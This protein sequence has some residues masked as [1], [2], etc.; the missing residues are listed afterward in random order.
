MQ[1]PAGH[2]T[3]Y[4]NNEAD[5]DSTNIYGNVYGG[6]H[7]PGRA[8][9]A[10]RS[11]AHQCLRDLR[12]THP[13]EDRA[14]IEDEKDTLLKDCYAWIL[15]DSGFRRWR[16]QADSQLLWIKGDPG[17]GKTMMIMGIIDELSQKDRARPSLRKIGSKH[18]LVAYF[19]CQRTRPELNNSVSVLRGLILLLV[20]KR[21]Q[22]I[23]HVQKRYETTGSKLFEGSN[24]IYALKE[25]LLDILND[26]SLPMTYLLVDALDECT[27]GLSAL[28]RI[29]ANDS[30]A[31]RSRVKWLVTSRNIPAIERYLQP[32]LAGIK[33][34]LELSA[35]HVSKAVAAYIDFKVRRLA[36]IRKY[37]HKTRAE[38]QQQLW[39]KAE[40][41]FLWV[42]LV[43]KELESMPLYSTRAVLHAIP[44]GLDPLYKRMME[45]ILA[46]KDVKTV[47]YCK[48]VLRSLTIAFRPLR[49]EELV[50]VA[51]LPGDQFNDVQGVADLVSYC[52]SFL[53]IRQDMVSFIHLS[54]K[55]FF[56]AGNSQQV[57]NGVVAEEQGRM[58]YRLLNVM[59]STLQRD[60]CGL[61]KLG[62]RTQEVAEQIK[63]SILPRIAYACEYWVDHLYDSNLISL[64]SYS[65]VLHNGSIVDVFLREKFLYWLEALSLCKNMS[66]GVVSIA[67]LKALTQGRLDASALNELV[68]DAHRFIMTHKSAIE[69][70]PLQAY[71]SALLF[72]PTRS[73]I[74]GLF[75]IEEPDWITIK[76][77][78]QEKWSPCLQTLEGHS[79]EV[80]S[81]RLASGS[82]S[83]LPWDDNTVK[84]WDVSSGERLHTL[85]GHSGGVNSIAFSHDSTRL[86]S[87]SGLGLPWDD[88]NTVKIWDVSSGECLHTLKGYSSAANSVAFSHDSTRLASGSSDSTVKI[89][90]V[91]S[92]ECLHTLKGHSNGIRS[93]AFSHDST[94]LASGSGS[95]M[96][97]GDNT[98]KIWDVSSGECLHTL[99]G[100]SNRVNSVAFSHN[101]T[102]LASGSGS[103]WGDSMIYQ[104]LGLSSDRTWITY[105]SENLLWLPSE[106]R[107]HFQ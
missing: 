96:P 54:A 4:T 15:D 42:S 67:K 1:S 12:V 60:L 38:V 83:G 81:T 19:F 29:I 86:A 51:G 106:Y 17:K 37:D 68:G 66:K 57:F 58:T 3:L 41:T 40:G 39:H 79:N 104:G 90:D 84:I 93:V 64:A 75:K 35:S 43:C 88:D 87:G 25:I 34:S 55:D 78:I 26:P 100:H 61:Q 6:L 89:W 23:Q 80:R 45:Q 14:R 16:T 20:E 74:K 22:L 48:D 105:N 30:L 62:A 102:R 63:D 99:E 33:I 7:I 18:A 8:D 77:A 44:P 46:Q 21:E 13:R 98:V 82:G 47:E 31:P 71:A 53:T 65:D 27:S 70:S 101:S 9:G 2:T 49:L 95:G 10:S 85:K 73:I 107:P 92:G 11:S 91:S 52:G 24:A 94:R 103:A 28:L 5:G 97:W 69:N 32:D 56:I 59:R 50:V 76:P 36:A 72:S